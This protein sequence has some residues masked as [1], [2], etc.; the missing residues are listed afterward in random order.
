MQMKA[1]KAAIFLISMTLSVA[2]PGLAQKVEHTVAR[3]CLDATLT[4]ISQ[5]GLGPT[6]HAR[7]LFHLSV[8]M[9]DAWAVYDSSASTYLLGK[10]I[11]GF[12]SEFD[13]FHYSGT[14]I[15]SARNV[16]IVIAAMR[17]MEMRFSLYSSKHRSLERFPDL[18]DSLGVNFRS[19][20]LNYSTGS[21][22]ALGNYIA[23]E[24]FRFGEQDGSNEEGGYEPFHYGPQN[25]PFN[26]GRPGTGKLSNPNHWQPIYMR[27]YI[28]KK[29]LDP[30][31]PDWNWKLAFHQEVFV[32]PE[33]GNVIPFS[34]TEDD[35]EELDR[36]GP[37]NVYLN[38]GPPPL[39]TDA[40][41]DWN[42]K[43]YKEGFVQ[44]IVWSGL[45][46]PSDSV[47][48]DISP[49]GLGKSPA[50]PESPDDYDAYYDL[51]NGSV[52]GREPHSINPVTQSE[53]ESNVV[54]R[55]DYLRVIAEYWV[56]AINTA[57]PPGHWM[58]HLSLTGYD[59]KFE[60]KWRGEG[61]TLDQLEWDVKS[62]FAMAGAMHDAA[63]ACW[64]IKGYYDYVRPITAIRYMGTKGQCWDSLMPSY[65][66]HGLPLI[67]GHIELVDE[68]DPLVG[69]SLEHLNKIKIY[70]WKGP[71]F[72][73]DQLKDAA[74]VGWILAENWWPYQRY[75]FATP[76]FA[77]YV[78]GHSTFSPCGAEML[79]IMTGSPYFPGGMHSFT[80]KK[81][82]FLQF[83]NGP[84][85]DIS[86]Q[87]ATFH[88]A[89]LETCLSRIYGG[90]HPPADDIPGRKIGISIAKK[91]IEK[92][93]KY[94]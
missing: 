93:E 44:N 45:L 77:G 3:R 92:A 69:D 59:E 38:P 50:L 16:T 94:F 63:I 62:Y 46:D 72:V 65:H 47:R 80:A 13:G 21:P 2:K 68:N 90:I 6:I 81:N 54:L 32:T 8:A 67:E 61:E 17:L 91:A 78:S 51:F 39:L 57:S 29:G 34:L 25:G 28:E 20:S 58:D 27:E 70:T 74:G 41:Q 49:A 82:E 66:P 11:Q 14:N 43:H 55:G 84:T 83:E 52:K 64:S 56:D 71:D 19:R 5:D 26:P 22:T 89:A 40:P 88:D 24:I 87:W 33:W 4:A 23:A 12:S 31:L 37:F 9:Y 10:Q 48:I 86:L 42:S 1:F 30:T 15:D 79:T 53:Y 35:K 76:S 36:D 18:C 7:N 85:E 73:K 60:R 75:S